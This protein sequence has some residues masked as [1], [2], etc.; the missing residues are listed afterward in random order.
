MPVRTIYFDEAGYTG[1]NLLDSVQPIFVIA[2]VD[3]EEQLASEILQSSFPKYQGGEFKFSNIWRSGNRAGLSRF[4]SNLEEYADKAYCYAINKRFSVLTKAI[5]FLIEPYMT[6]SGYDFYGEGFCWKYANYIHYGLSEFEPPELLSAL[7]AF[8]LEFSREPSEITLSR[9][10]YRLDLMANSLDTQGKIFIE[11]F[12]L[13][14]RL[15]KDF[16]DLDTFKSSNNLYTTVML[17]LVAHWRQKHPEDFAVVHDASSTFL[18]DRAV[19]EA[20]TKSDIPKTEIPMGDGSFAEYPMRV[21]STAALDS[22]ASSS[23]Q[24]CDILAGLTARHFDPNLDA[25]ARNFMSRMIDEGLCHI[26]CNRIMP[27]TEFPVQI[28]PRKL[29]GPDAVDQFSALLRGAKS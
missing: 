27:G 9:L 8:Y 25:E 19:W 18:R 24:F 12:A 17:T 5:D 26:S 3:I 13:G 28:P 16:N 20:A 10:Q 22:Q 15:F 1:Y 23:I 4:C 29:F 21:V 7:L 14:A 6:D 2:S 11:Q